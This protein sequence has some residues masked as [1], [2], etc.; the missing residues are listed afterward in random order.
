VL[1]VV[2]GLEELNDALASFMERR[3]RPVWQHGADGPHGIDQIDLRFVEPFE[4]KAAFAKP[5]RVDMCSPM[6]QAIRAELP[7][8]AQPGVEQWFGVR[9]VTIG[10]EEPSAL[11]E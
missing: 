4:P 3:I 1:L 9:R 7:Q 6:H 5:V 11:A 10:Q 8:M 2:P